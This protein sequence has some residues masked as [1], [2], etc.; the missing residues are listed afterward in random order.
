M[1]TQP[2]PGA[3]L[4][5]HNSFMDSNNGQHYNSIDDASRAAG[6]APFH[7]PAHPPVPQP[8]PN[9]L[10]KRTGNLRINERDFKAAKNYRE[11]VHDSKMFGFNEMRSALQN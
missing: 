11:F 8:D 5:V 1:N 2:K 4:L 3:I 6:Y 9:V 7:F 10:K